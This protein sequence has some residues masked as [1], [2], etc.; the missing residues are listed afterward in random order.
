MDFLYHSWPWYVAGPLIGLTVPALLL[1]GNK[2]LGVSSTLRQICAACVPGGLSLFQY[3]WKKDNWNLF[4]AAGMILGGFLGGIVFA[5]PDPVSISKTT[6]Q[7]FHAKGLTDLSGLMP[8]ELFNWK[9]LLTVRG[10]LMIVVGGFMVGFGTRWAKGCTSGHGILGLSALQWPSL[11]AT[12]SFFTGGILFS[13]F[14][15]PSILTL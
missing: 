9:A 7:Y 8:A 6:I 2:N 10:F 4:F 14:I 15:L 11:L 3:N 13:K 12:A 5:N 1:L